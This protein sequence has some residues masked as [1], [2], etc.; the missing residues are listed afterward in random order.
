MRESE[1]GKDGSAR[2]DTTVLGSRAAATVPKTLCVQFMACFVA[3]ARD[4]KPMPHVHPLWK[5]STKQVSRCDV[6]R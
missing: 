1:H 5:W 2:G 3:A 4:L 6:R